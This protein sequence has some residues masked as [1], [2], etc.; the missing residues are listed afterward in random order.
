MKRP[1]VFVCIDSKNRTEMCK[2]FGIKKSSITYG[3]YW[4]ELICRIQDSVWWQSEVPKKEQDNNIWNGR[5]ALL[6]C[7]F[8]DESI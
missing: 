5:A 3:G 4:D 1:D 8:Y 7:I 2:D 6:D